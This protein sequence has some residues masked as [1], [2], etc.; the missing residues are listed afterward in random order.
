MSMMSW[1]LTMKMQQQLLLKACH[2]LSVTS[3]HIHFSS[4]GLA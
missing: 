1:T 3:S 2:F 4:F